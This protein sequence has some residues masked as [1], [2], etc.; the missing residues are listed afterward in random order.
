MI[1]E[2]ISDEEKSKQP[3]YNQPQ[4]KG[5]KSEKVSRNKSTESDTEIQKSTVKKY[6]ESGE[7]L[8]T[9]TFDS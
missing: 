4:K 6:R 7:S 1:L 9:V 3:K 2:L 8:A 5:T